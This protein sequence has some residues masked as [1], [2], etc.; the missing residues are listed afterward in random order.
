MSEVTLP[1]EEKKSCEVCGRGPIH[2]GRA[3]IYK[4]NPVDK[5][6]VE[7]AA[8]SLETAKKEVSVRWLSCCG[9]FNGYRTVVIY[10]ER[11]ELK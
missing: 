5:K 4:S 8:K 1:K 10:P 9:A 2:N 7:Q 11:K 6:R 3:R